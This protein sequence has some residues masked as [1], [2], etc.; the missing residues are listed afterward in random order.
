MKVPGYNTWRVVDRSRSR[1]L[2]C[3]KEPI[4]HE[5]NTRRFD[6]IWYEYESFIK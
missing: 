3:G 5:E 4:I 6:N 2:S 1:V